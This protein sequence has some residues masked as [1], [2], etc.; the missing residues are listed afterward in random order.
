[1]YYS[2]T[3]SITGLATSA[4]HELI[5]KRRSKHSKFSGSTTGGRNKTRTIAGPHAAH[6]R[7]H[8]I[9][10]KK[11]IHCIRLLQFDY[12]Y[13]TNAIFNSRHFVWFET[14]VCWLLSA[15]LAWNKA[16]GI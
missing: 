7:T 12:I 2:A 15:F 10:K 6:S 8:Y 13:F 3:I 14:I 16:A 11:K 1:M 5:N 9:K 4:I